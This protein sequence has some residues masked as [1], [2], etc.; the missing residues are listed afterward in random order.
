[1]LVTLAKSVDY[2]LCLRSY[3]VLEIESSGGSWRIPIVW[4]WITSSLYH[5]DSYNVILLAVVNES[6][7]VRWW[8]TT[9]LC[10]NCEL[11]IKSW[12][13]H[14]IFC[15]YPGYNASTVVIGLLLFGSSTMDITIGVSKHHHC[16]MAWKTWKIVAKSP[17]C[18]PVRSRYQSAGSEG[19]VLSPI[20]NAPC[21]YCVS[22][23]SL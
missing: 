4:W 23:S 8:I 22:V 16:H 13:Y 19:W 7:A 17:Q 3:P 6:L 10:L 9:C 2:L 11:F 18:H 1:M 14:Y 15:H 5:S 21:P 12:I 20:L